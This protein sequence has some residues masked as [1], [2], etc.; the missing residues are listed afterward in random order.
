MKRKFEIER[1]WSTAR[2][3]NDRGSGLFCNDVK[4]V[5]L[6]AVVFGIAA[7]AATGCS[8]TAGG[9]TAR[10]IDPVASDQ[11]GS[12]SGA[13]DFYHRPRNPGFHDLTGS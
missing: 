7:L 3:L 8:S 1:P 11:Q 13:D 5:A 6:L 4:R 9:V 2:T 12:V 10:L